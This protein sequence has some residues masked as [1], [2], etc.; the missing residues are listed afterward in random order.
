ME[1]KK[2]IKTKVVSKANVKEEPKKTEKMDDMTPKAPPEPEKKK[3]GPGLLEQ[4]CAHFQL[5]T[6]DVESFKED[7]EHKFIVIQL[8]PSLLSKK[9]RYPT[10]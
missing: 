5:K 9:L 8:I 4:A 2:K 3:T 10:D 7:P 1:K 6:S